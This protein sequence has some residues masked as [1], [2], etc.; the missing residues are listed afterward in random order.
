MARK[1]STRNYTSSQNQPPS[2]EVTNSHSNKPPEFPKFAP[3]E[4]YY[5]P[6]PLLISHIL[7]H[8]KLPTQIQ[9]PS[10]N[11]KLHGVTLEETMYRISNNEVNK[12]HR[13]TRAYL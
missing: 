3:S 9:N 1:H 7:L 2:R 6:N 12:L 10:L 5:T 8:L 4:Q 11:E 13:H